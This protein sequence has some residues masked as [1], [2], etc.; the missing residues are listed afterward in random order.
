MNP[1][2][3]VQLGLGLFGLAGIGGIWFRLGSLTQGHKG[4][5]ARVDHLEN[6]VFRGAYKT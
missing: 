4:M 3:F 2:E 6:H 5:E 1:L